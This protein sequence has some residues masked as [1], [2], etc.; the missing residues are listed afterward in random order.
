[1]EH[2]E[3]I[4][5]VRL[6]KEIVLILLLSSKVRLMFFFLNVPLAHYVLK[7]NDTDIIQTVQKVLNRTL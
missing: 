6:T 4:V 5:H 7:M 3:G 2:H 1:M